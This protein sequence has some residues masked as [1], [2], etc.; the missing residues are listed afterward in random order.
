METQS[1]DSTIT[2]PKM[3]PTLVTGFNTVAANIALI[4]APLLLDV[5]LWLGPHFS[6]QNALQPLVDSTFSTY[7]AM[8]NATGA[9]T[10]PETFQQAFE[11]MLAQ[12]NVFSVVRTYPLGIPSLL[13]GENFTT[14]PMGSVM[15]VDLPSVDLL[16]LFWLVLVLA[17]IFV[18]CLYF[19]ALCRV[20][21]PDK[22]KFSLR[23]VMQQYGQVL[24]FTIVLLIVLFFLIIPGVSV[25]SFLTS[26]AGGLAQILLLVMVFMGV[27]LLLPLIFSIHGIF[28]NKQRAFASVT[29]SIRMVRVFLPGTGMFIL[30]AILLNQGLSLL[31]MLPGTTNWMLAVGIAGHAFIST[32]LLA[33]TFVYYRGGLVW[34][35]EAIRRMNSRVTPKI[36]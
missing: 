16:A 2:P 7:R 17:G 13:F 26:S 11:Q 12:F 10:M 8:Q 34:M 33:A 3:I 4:L 30:T 23:L 19:D 21:A 36:S 28:V 14:N 25:M 18:G 5:F 24:S 27:W 31:W 20:T 29:T 15:I 35:Q 32:G 6:M 22:Q 9:A 1:A